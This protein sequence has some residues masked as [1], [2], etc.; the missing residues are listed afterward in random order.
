MH[1][2]RVASAPVLALVALAAAS[3]VAA[4]PIKSDEEVLLFPTS[5]HRDGDQWV[6]PVHG[7]VYE[8]ERDSVWR[9][10]LV[11]SLC[12]ALGLT[13]EQVDDGPFVDRVSW[14]LVDSERG[15]RLSIRLA[16]R[17]HAIG[18]TAIDGHVRADLHVD[19]IP[20][21]RIGARG[22]IAYEAALRPGDPRRFL[23]DVQLVDPTG[24]SIV[25]DVD[26]TIKITEVTSRRRTLVN[27]FV[28]PFRPVPGMPALYRRWE[29]AG[30][31]FHYVS[32]S[33]WQLYP[34]LA[35]FLDAEGFPRGTFA[36]REHRFMDGRVTNLLSSPR[37]HKLQAIRAL[38]RRYPDR[39]FVL[40]GD[41]SESDPEIFGDLAREFPERIERILIRDDPARRMTGA[42]AAEAF[43]QLPGKALVFADPARLPAAIR[44]GRFIADR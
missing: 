12:D 24:V 5:A 18:A 41:S 39:R 35:A 7:W 4:S 9:S 40:V 19:G 28:R 1:G 38:L 25:S 31:V 6:I 17:A 20:D 14:F 36:L 15:K 43:R 37:P 30:A 34:A 3:R 33:P 32:A 44:A 10:G 29:S 11:T 2:A 8:P 42:R 22:W 23:G 21:E 13:R 27:T 26:D 16:G